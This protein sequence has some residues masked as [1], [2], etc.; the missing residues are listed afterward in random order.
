MKNMFL[1]DLTF[2]EQNNINKAVLG[3]TLILLICAAVMGMFGV[4]QTFNAVAAFVLGLL[5][6]LSP[7]SKKNTNRD[8]RTVYFA[9]LIVSDAMYVL[10]LFFLLGRTFMQNL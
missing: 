9:I 8:F 7:L 5:Y 1:K 3:L 6:F 10:S 4:Y 2:E